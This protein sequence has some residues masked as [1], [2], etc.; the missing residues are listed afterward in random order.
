MTSKR[1]P[2]SNLFPG[3]SDG[4]LFSQSYANIRI[5]L[6]MILRISSMSYEPITTRQQNDSMHQDVQKDIHVLPMPRTFNS[7]ISPEALPDDF[8]YDLIYD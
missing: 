6:G 4:K 7:E 1:M 2:F 5:S 3:T 8:T